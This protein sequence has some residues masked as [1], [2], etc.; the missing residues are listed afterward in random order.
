MVTLKEIGDA[1]GVSPSTVSAVI[2]NKSHCYVSE[3][4]RKL[5][6]STADRLGYLPNMNSRALKGLPTRTI[7][8]ISGI[9]SVPIH[10]ELISHIVEFLN[11]RGYHVMLGDSKGEHAKENSLIKEFISRGIDGIIINSTRKTDDIHAVIPGYD[12]SIVNTSN[13][14]KS[15]DDRWNLSVNLPK[16]EYLA[17]EH[18][19]KRHKRRKIVFYTTG[20][21]ANMLKFAGYRQALKDNNIDFSNDLCMNISTQKDKLKYV[22]NS[23]LKLKPDAVV[24]TNDMLALQLI[25]VLSDMKIKVPDDIAVIGYDGLNICN[26]SS[27]SLSTVRQPMETLAGKTVDILIN[28]IENKIEPGKPSLVEPK[29]VRRESCGCKSTNADIFFKV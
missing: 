23:I 10:S 4:K 20:L 5:V 13:N 26:V 6:L 29:L 27:P 8:I 11:L 18:L 7:G 15:M 28:K 22:R 24:T 16:G 25:R 2:H 12:T 9:F 17:V 19:I 3:L 1:A 21:D 14:P